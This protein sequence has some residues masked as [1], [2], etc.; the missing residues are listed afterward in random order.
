MM[1]EFYDSNK[2][3]IITFLAQKD[4]MKN[5]FPKDQI[6]L[7]LK[8]LKYYSIDS[9]KEIKGFLIN[10]LNKKISEDLFFDFYSEIN[11]KRVGDVLE[12]IKKS[13]KYIIFINQLNK[14]IERGFV[15][16]KFIS[17]CNN[18]LIFYNALTIEELNSLVNI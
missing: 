8:A 3:S 1:D 17:E 11:N 7:Y 12:E 15:L 18:I 9:D 14:N 6:I 16:S 13:N 10:E 4:L 2:N 5:Y